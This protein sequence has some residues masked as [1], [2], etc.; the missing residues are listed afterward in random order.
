MNHLSDFTK[1]KIAKLY[2]G[3]PPEEIGKFREFCDAYPFRHMTHA[4]IQWPYL[5]SSG[6]GTPLLILSGALTHPDLSWQSIS[7]F[8]EKTRIL[9]PAYP[10]VRT[11]D[12]LCGGIAAIL[13]HEGMEN[14][15]V[16]GGSYGGF[17]AQVF[18]R[19]FPAMTRSLIL[20]HTAAPDSTGLEKTRRMWKALSHLPNGVLRRILG[21]AMGKLTPADA[22]SPAALFIMAMFHEVMQHHLA[23]A[24]LLAVMDRTLDFY[25]RN[26]TTQDLAGWPGKILLVLADD[27]PASPERVRAVLRTLYPEARLHL[28]HGTGHITAVTNQTEYLAVMDEFLGF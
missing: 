1:P 12:E 26:F 28:F 23:K 18:V 22:A 9:V 17:V 27:D 7:H 10:A 4:G 2:A 21:R 6:T 15:H 3:V 8:G 25:G 16:M 24:D 20:S 13:R 14:A 19:R 11:M 5:A